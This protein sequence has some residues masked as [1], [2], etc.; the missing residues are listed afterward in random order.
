MN[1]LKEKNKID[2]YKI[3]WIAFKVLLNKRDINGN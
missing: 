2:N 1:Q 3:G